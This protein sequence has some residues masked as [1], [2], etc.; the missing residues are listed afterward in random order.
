MDELE[1]D[2]EDGGLA[3]WG[4]DDVLLPDLFEHGARGVGG[5]HGVYWSFG[6]L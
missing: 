5:F 3:G 2:V 1:V 4:D 6:V